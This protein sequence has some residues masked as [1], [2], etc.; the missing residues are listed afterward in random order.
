MFIIPP[1]YANLRVTNTHTYLLAYILLHY[2]IW[3]KNQLIN[4]Q[5]SHGLPSVVMA[6][7]CRRGPIARLAAKLVLDV[8]GRFARVTFVLGTNLI[9][10]SKRLTMPQRIGA[11]K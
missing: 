9:S 3:V 10:A 4:C 11:H 5:Y 8:V 1:S 2:L 7:M 6:Q